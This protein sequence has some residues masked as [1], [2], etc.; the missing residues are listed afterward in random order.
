MSGLEVS[1]LCDR[2]VR[3]IEYHFGEL[4]LEPNE[5][6]VCVLP[7]TNII[8]WLHGRSDFMS[9]KLKGASP[10]GR[11][12]ICDDAD[13]WL[14]WYHD[15]RKQQLAIQRVRLPIVDSQLQSAALAAMLLDAV[16]EARAWNFPKIILWDPS[17]EL[18]GA[19]SIL[20]QEFRIMSEIEAERQ[21]GVPSI[22]WRHADESNKT[23]FHF[24][25]F[26][27]RN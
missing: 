19:M 25:E 27:T 3:D 22:R 2:D 14:Y 1:E 9:T 16:E 12:S 4:I 26:Y 8:T 7:T 11:G 13:A 20:Q 6:H 21:R 17:T 18:L 23:T 5:S 15:F 24:H 10:I